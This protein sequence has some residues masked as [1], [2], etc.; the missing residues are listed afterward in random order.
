MKKNVYKNKSLFRV[1]HKNVLKI[2][3][4]TKDQF[5][6]KV[7]RYF[8]DKDVD[9]APE[10]K[11]KTESN[12]YENLLT[13]FK[14]IYETYQRLKKEADTITKREL[15]EITKQMNSKLN[16]RFFETSVPPEEMTKFLEFIAKDWDS[17]VKRIIVKL[18]IEEEE[19]SNAP[20]VKDETLERIMAQ[21]R[22]YDRERE[23][24]YK[25]VDILRSRKL[26]LEEKC[27]REMEEIDQEI[28]ELLNFL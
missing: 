12:A 11:Y 13:R 2:D 21:Q 9:Y 16:F 4:D 17:L 25:D 20:P 7:K 26:K 24:V 27:I 3:T 14:S 28:E 23:E 6:I 22:Q 15:V 18:K 8:E 5:L 19:N 1:K 10:F